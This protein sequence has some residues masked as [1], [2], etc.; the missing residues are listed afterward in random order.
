MKVDQLPPCH[1]ASDINT[2]KLLEV[3]LANRESGFV[4]AIF[5]KMLFAQLDSSVDDRL[6][7]Y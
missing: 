2:R 6:D 4:A 3:M 7:K 1:R 5:S